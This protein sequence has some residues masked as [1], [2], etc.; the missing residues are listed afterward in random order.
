MISLFNHFKIIEIDFLTSSGFIP[1]PASSGKLSGN[2]AP[3][4]VLNAMFKCI[5]ERLTTCQHGDM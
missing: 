2:L 5:P 4:E 3:Y 1:H